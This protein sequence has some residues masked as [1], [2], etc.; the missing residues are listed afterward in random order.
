METLSTIYS[1][2]LHFGQKP[3]S[4]MTGGKCEPS[5]PVQYDFTKFVCAPI[6]FT[7]K[8]TKKKGKSLARN[9]QPEIS[10]NRR[11]STRI[12]DVIRLI[13][14]VLVSLPSSPLYKAFTTRQSNIKFGRPSNPANVFVNEPNIFILIFSLTPPTK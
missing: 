2:E 14:P 13:N 5:S 8:Y 10:G 3:L 11:R 7:K 12:N 4:G 6:K 1:G 9:S